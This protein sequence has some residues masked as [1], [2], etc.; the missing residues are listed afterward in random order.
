MS[1]GALALPAAPG[2]LVKLGSL[3]C[4]L[5]GGAQ[6]LISKILGYCIFMGSFFL[7]MPQLLKI[8][9]ARSVT[10]I[11]LSARYSEVPINSS[12]V[13]YHFLLGLPIST[14]GENV[15]VLVQN[16]LLVVA[17]WVYRKPRVPVS[18]MVLATAAFILLCVVQLNLPPSL[19]P[20]LIYLNIPFGIGSSLPQIIDNARQGHTGQLA[21]LTCLMK[22]AGCTIRLFTT[23]TQIGLDPGLLLSYATGAILNI[24]LLVQGWIYRDETARVLAAEAEVKRVEDEEE[25]FKAKSNPDSPP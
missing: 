22:L 1:A 20:L 25:A 7:Q 10:G 21:M 17:V 9:R 14:Y 11:S 12:T 13:I 18:N 15:V 2:K 19:L 8:F 4:A 23:V 24:I 5:P 16:L 6:L 3:A